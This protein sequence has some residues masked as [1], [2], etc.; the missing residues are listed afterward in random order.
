ERCKARGHE[1]LCVKPTSTTPSARLK[2][3]CV[4]CRRDSKKCDAKRPCPYCT[5][6]GETCVEEPR[7]GRGIGQ[8]VKRACM[9][10]RKDKVQCGSERPCKRCAKRGLECVERDD[11]RMDLDPDGEGEEDTEVPMEGSPSHGMCR[12]IPISFFVVND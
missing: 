6:I 11:P 4:A 5:E 3:R 10:C 2:L 8:R 9:L 1:S 7:K 12:S